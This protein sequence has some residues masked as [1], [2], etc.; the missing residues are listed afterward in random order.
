MWT[1]RRIVLW[2]GRADGIE[3]SYDPSRLKGIDA[4]R[5]VEINLAVGDRLQFTAP[6]RNLGVANRDQGIVKTVDSVG[7][8]SVQM[9]NGK[10]LTFDTREMRHLDYGYAVTSQ[11]SQGLTTSRVLIHVDT[12]V[13]AELVSDRFAYVAVSRASQEATIY[14]NSAE[15][16]SQ[17]VGHAQGK[18]TAINISLPAPN[19]VFT[20][21]L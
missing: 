5:A 13:H 6:M 11:S 4:Y 21:A 16:L 20:Q 2:F 7:H 1:A 8:V 18:E 10:N 19:D 14:T 15:R 9:D 3:V 12:G 17:M